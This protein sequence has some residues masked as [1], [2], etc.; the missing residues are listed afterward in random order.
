MAPSTILVVG[1]GS[2]SVGENHLPQI[3]VVQTVYTFLA[4]TAV[5]L[6]LYVRIRL[7]KNPGYDDWS[8]F[9]AAVRSSLPSWARRILSLLFWAE[10]WLNPHIT[11]SWHWQH[12]QSCAL[13]GW[14]LYI[15]E[16]AHGL[17]HSDAW[18][19]TGNGD[20][21]KITQGTFWQSIVCSSLGMAM[22]KIS[23]ALNLLRLSPARWYVYCL[24][25]SIVRCRKTAF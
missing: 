9:I 7:I 13:G 18:F 4:V 16:A 21:K 5:A 3:L 10:R 23:I 1:R 12:D 2:A 6:R 20:E 25:G 8:I 15:F 22:L 14:I 24:W 17:G 11:L 19:D